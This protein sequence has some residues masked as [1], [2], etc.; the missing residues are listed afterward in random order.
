MSCLTCN[1]EKD[2]CSACGRAAEVDD[3]GSAGAAEAQFISTEL[4]LTT[5]ERATQ[6]TVFHHNK[7]GL[8]TRFRSRGPSSQVYFCKRLRSF[9]KA[10]ICFGALSPAL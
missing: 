1:Q 5:M 6:E 7:A 2:A 9:D 10:V 8:A 4:Q 3:A